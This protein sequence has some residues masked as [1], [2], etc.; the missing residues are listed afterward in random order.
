[1]KKTLIVGV[2]GFT[3]L[4]LWECL[5]EKQN[6]KIIGTFHRSL[7]FSLEQILKGC[8]LVRCNVTNQKEIKAVLSKTIPDEIY[9]LSSIV[10]VARSFEMAADIYDT[11]VLGTEKFLKS[12]VEVCPK[13]RILISGSAEEYGKVG[14]SSLPLRENHPLSPVSPYGLSKM[15]QEKLAEYYFL[16]HQ[17]NTVTTR[18][19]HFAGVR[20]PR[21]F[22]VSDFASQIADIEAGDKEPV[23]RVGNLEA[24]RDFTDIRDV[25]R[26]YSLIMEKKDARGVFNVCSGR[27]VPVQF[28]LDELLAQSKCKISVQNDPLKMRKADVPD[29]RGDHL[30]LTKATGWKPR[31]SLKQ[32][33]TDVLNWWRKNHGT[34]S[35]N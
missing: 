22:V 20:Q 8:S 3:G 17:L 19:F 7:N 24:R 12:C 35:V 16:N 26:A 1:M 15:L 18:T 21:T 11:N 34:S 32:T 33:L 30:K 9:F 25:V 5:K 23:I 28:I 4:H 14:K 13:A 31:I 27:S 6:S 2:N 10:T 29:F